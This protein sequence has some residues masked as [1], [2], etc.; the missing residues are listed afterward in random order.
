M[1]FRGTAFRLNAALMDRDPAF[2][3]QQLADDGTLRGKLPEVDGLVGFG[4]HG[5][6]HKD[7]WDHTKRVVSQVEPLPHLIQ[8]IS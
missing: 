4:G 8:T 2:Q 6:G 7:L 5:Q 1:N 3:L